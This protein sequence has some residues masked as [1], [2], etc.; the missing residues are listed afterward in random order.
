MHINDGRKDMR[1]EEL[2]TIVITFDDNEEVE[3]WV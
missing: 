1:M 2:E 3:F